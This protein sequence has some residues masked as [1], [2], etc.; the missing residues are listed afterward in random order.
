[1]AEIQYEDQIAE[2]YSVLINTIKN[3]ITHCHYKR[4]TELADLYKK[5]ITGDKIEELLR[6]FVLREDD[7][8]FAQRKQMTQAITPSVAATIM[9]PFYRVGRVNSIIRNIDF[10]EESDRDSKLQN[11]NDAISLYYGD[12]GLDK[13]LETRLV[14]LNFCD[15]NSFIVTEFDEPE[16]DIQGNFLE[17]VKPR[18]FEVSSHDAINFFYKNNILQWLIVKLPIEYSKKTGEEHKSE[19]GHSYTIYLNDIAIRFTQVDIDLFKTLTIGEYAEIQYESGTVKY[20]RLSEDS[21][22]S[23]EEFEYKTGKVP[24]FRVGYKQDLVT[25]GQTFV[26][27]L[28]EAL[29]YFMKSIKSVSEFDLTMALHAFPQKF[30]YIGVCEVEQCNAGYM[31]AGEKCTTCKGTGKAIHTTTQDIV[32]MRMPKDPNDIVDLEKLVHYEYPPVE[33]LKFQDEFI[34]Q[35][36]NEAR[37]A[38]FNSEIFNKSQVVSTATEMRISMESVYDTLFP[39]AEKFS[40]SWKYIVHLIAKLRDVDD[41]LL[42]HRFPKDFRFKTVTDLLGE[43]KL[44]NDSGAPGYVKTEISTAISHQQFIDKPEELKRI[45]VKQKFYPFPDKTGQEILFIISSDLTSERNKILWSEFDDIFAALEF[46]AA[47]KGEYYYDYKPKKQKELLDA[48][49]LKRIEAMKTDEP[50]P[51]VAVEEEAEE[52]EAEL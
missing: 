3:K 34:F 5:V 11:I 10:N 33:L 30:Q 8:M 4:V 7:V 46:H 1:M 32:T 9:N 12:D 21:L 14:D 50:V 45:L 49:V 26:S 13:Y 37:Q 18:P 40:K 25:K 2:G 29:P 42:E 27:P 23:I 48:E 35:L 19:K 6:Q 15:P 16:K 28:H 31:P 39:F 36:K 51:L 41:V 38:V 24:A 43:L 22:F 47:G 44:A 17:K 52:P 20:Y